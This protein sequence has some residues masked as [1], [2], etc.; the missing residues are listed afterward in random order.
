M[1]FRMRDIDYMP[2]IGMNEEQREEQRKVQEDLQK[3]GECHFGANTFV[4]PL[5]AVFSSRLAMGDHS[6]IA[7]GAIVRGADVEIGANSTVNSYAVIAGKVRIGEGVRIA[8]HA[9]LYGF[10]H[11]YA[12]VEIPIYRQPCTTVGIEIADDVWI[13]AG[14]VVV[15]GV[16]IGA[17][18]ILAAGAVVTKDVPPYSIVGGCPARVLR[19]RL[20]ADDG[21]GLVAATVEAEA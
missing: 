17:H 1:E 6:Y 8:S 16:K 5:A 7:A 9:S 11:G 4:S 10:N 21:R 13:G 18:S 15:D 2:W 3:Q 12:S 19:S 20:A 14:V